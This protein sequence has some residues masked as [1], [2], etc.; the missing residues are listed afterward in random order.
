MFYLMFDKLIGGE[1]LTCAYTGIA[2]QM[3]IF[4]NPT[5]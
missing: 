3:L 2:M 1:K 5:S 4:A